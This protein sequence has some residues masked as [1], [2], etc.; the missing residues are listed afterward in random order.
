MVAQAETAPWARVQTVLDVLDTA[1]A[2]T[3]GVL[4]QGAAVAAVVYTMAV[5]L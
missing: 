5:T 3:A 1:Q 2:E 4:L